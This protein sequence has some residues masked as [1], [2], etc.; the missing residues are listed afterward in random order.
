MSV[1]RPLATPILDTQLWWQNVASIGSPDSSVPVSVPERAEI[2]PSPTGTPSTA[3]LVPAIVTLDVCVRHE[4]DAHGTAA[5]RDGRKA[6]CREAARQ[7][8]AADRDA[9]VVREEKVAHGAAGHRDGGGIR[10][11][12]LRG[13][14]AQCDLSNLSA[15]R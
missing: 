2:G 3:K 10:S 8:A 14:A 15:A 6:G 7:R 1:M 9:G 5:D 12:M 11:E 4:I 13:T